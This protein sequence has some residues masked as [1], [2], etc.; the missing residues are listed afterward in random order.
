MKLAGV[1]FER[2]RCWDGERGRPARRQWRPAA[3]IER[4]RARNPSPMRPARR[5]TR[6]AGHPRSPEIL[7][8]A[9]VST[10]KI[11]SHC[12]LLLFVLGKYGH[13]NDEMLF[14]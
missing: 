4:E 7:R 3:G 14:F 12:G 6:R 13:Y 9:L 5:R 1:I 10:F 11:L 2:P 8:C